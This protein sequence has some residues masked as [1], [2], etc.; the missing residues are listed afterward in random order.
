MP[1]RGSITTRTPTSSSTRR[2]Q[3]ASAA[4]MLPLALGL[5]GNMNAPQSRTSAEPTAATKQCRPSL[6]SCPEY[7]CDAEGSAHALVN[8]MKRRLPTQGAPKS[9]TWDDFTTLQEDA[10]STVGQEKELDESARAR[11]HNIRVSSGSVSEGDLVQLDGFLVGKPH[12]NTGESVNCNLPG[13][14][15]ND[16]HIPFAD[17]PDKTPFQGIVVEMIPQDRP[18]NW[19]TKLLVKIENA[20]RMV[21]FVGQLFYDNMHRVNGDEEAP[22]SGQPP[23]FSL[24]EIHPITAVTVCKQP[25]TQCANWETLDQFVAENQAASP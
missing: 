20:R 11:L 19:N 14:A 25:D 13:P 15:N 21:R 1:T 6:S 4:T 10:D 2:R 16:F 18:A 17:D 3:L 5:A 23:R 12:P 8:E 22:Q 7:G 9:L 24:F